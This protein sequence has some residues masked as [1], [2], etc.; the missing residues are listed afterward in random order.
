MPSIE[1]NSE[2]QQQ[3][4]EANVCQSERCWQTDHHEE[5]R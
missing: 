3:H 4:R 5:T 1:T 2:Y